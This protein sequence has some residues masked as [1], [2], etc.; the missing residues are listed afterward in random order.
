MPR[1]MSEARYF[2]LAALLDGRRHG[3]GII[4]QAAD[5][6]EGRVKLSAGTLYGALDALQRQGLVA[7]DGEE[8]VSGR[9]RRYYRL[10]EAGLGALR[11]E[12]ERLRRAAQ[13]VT[14]RVQPA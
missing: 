4:Q 2:V 7:P 1:T 12:A 11:A 6:S 8:T 10:S 9:L 14:V 5:L 13:V 3:Y